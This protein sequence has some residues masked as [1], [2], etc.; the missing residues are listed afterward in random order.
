MNPLKSIPES[1]TI[2][3]VL[4]SLCPAIF[5]TKPAAKY[6]LT[7]L[8]DNLLKKTDETTHAY[9]TTPKAKEF[10][11]EVA[12]ISQSLF[13]VSA[14]AT[15]K[16]KYHSHAFKTIRLVQMNNTAGV[17][18][19]WRPILQL[20]AI[21]LLCVAAH[22][23]GRYESADQYL[24][25]YSNDAEL[26]KYATHFRWKIAKD[27]VA[28]FAAEYFRTSED[29]ENK[30]TEATMEYLWRKYLKEHKFPAV[31]G[32]Q[33]FLSTAIEYFPGKHDADANCFRGLVSSHSVVIDQFQRFW[34]ECVVVDKTDPLAEYEVD[35]LVMLYRHWSKNSG[36]SSCLQESITESQML[37][38]IRYYQDVEIIDN[39][40]VQ[41]VKSGLWDKQQDLR[42]FFSE[43]CK[44]TER[45]EISFYDAYTAYQSF[46]K[47][48]S[49]G[50]VGDC[51]YKNEIKIL[52][53]EIHNGWD[54][55]AEN[56]SRIISKKYFETYIYAAF[57]QDAVQNGKIC[58]R[59]TY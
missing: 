39:K 34:K 28:E 19:I 20:R 7:V 50:E 4:D 38:L 33:G 49:N 42:G 57:E 37:E 52:N 26:V 10:L 53:S 40:F 54:F 17:E 21:D 13:G 30:I 5:S 51:V 6:F 14:T 24:E 29:A 48:P 25:M 45:E 46:C 3:S 18:P 12:A 8:G 36:S 11:R 41:G 43:F 32:S 9:F 22:Y 55:I 56:S 23:S 58:L 1:A 44:V 16:Y 35:E 2:Q 59:V 31:L 47:S 27:V 15:F